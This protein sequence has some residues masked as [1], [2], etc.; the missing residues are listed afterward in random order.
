[1]NVCPAIRISPRRV[2][3]AEPATENVTVPLPTPV[4]PDL[5]EIQETRLM[6]VH[7][8]ADAVVTATLP[9]PPCESNVAAV[10]SSVN[11]HG[12]ASWVSATRWS[13]TAMLAVLA[14][15]DGLAAT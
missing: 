7:S 4:A 13:L 14:T 6:A 11:R 3:A 2:S 12:A 1:V 10:R 8:H 15:G 5:I 9:V